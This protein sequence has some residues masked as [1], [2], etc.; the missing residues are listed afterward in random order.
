MDLTTAI[1][2]SDT[3]AV[4]RLLNERKLDIGIVSQ[5]VLEPHVAAQTLGINEF[6]WIASTAVDV[7]QG[8][9]SPAD[10]A[11]LHLA[12]SPPTARL[13]ATA[14]AWFAR[15]GVV[16]AGL[17]TCNNLAVTRLAILSGIV[18]GLVPVRVMREELERGEVKLLQLSPPIPGHVV[19]LCYQTSEFGPSLQQILEV[20]RGLV[21]DF[22]LFA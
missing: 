4:S 15:A 9:L 1:H 20:I 8:A 5:P 16:P 13:H 17:S 10:I 7:P 22:A 2:V 14:M 6:C 11:R 21:A 19:S 18:T 3:G 12:I